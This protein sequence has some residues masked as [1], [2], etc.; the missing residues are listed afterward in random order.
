MSQ[1]VK[2]E[3]FINDRDDEI[4]QIMETIVDLA[5]IMKDLS[6]LVVEQGSILDRYML[7]IYMVFIYHYSMIIKN[8]N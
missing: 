3:S 2:K 6:I 1:I 4:Q 5:Q 7:F 8:C